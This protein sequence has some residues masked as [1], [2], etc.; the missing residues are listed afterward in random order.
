MLIFTAQGENRMEEKSK[1]EVGIE[2]VDLGIDSEDR[3]EPV[4]AATHCCWGPFSPLFW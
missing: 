4:T 2:I 3:E 1:E